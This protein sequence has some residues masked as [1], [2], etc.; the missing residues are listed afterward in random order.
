MNYDKKKLEELRNKAA[1]QRK[2][3]KETLAAIDEMKIK[4]NTC[5]CK[6]LPNEECS[7]CGEPNIVEFDV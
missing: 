1:E 7:C 2:I 4:C 5:R 3:L 6:I